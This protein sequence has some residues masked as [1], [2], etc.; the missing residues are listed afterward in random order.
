[1]TKG[2]V[3]LVGAG[4]GDP[5]LM[6]VRARDLLRRADVV[7]P[8]RLAP[9]DLE[10]LAPDAR[11]AQP[12]RLIR[13]ARAGRRVV[14]LRA[15]DPMTFGHVDEEIDAL[16]RAGI[17]F[18]IVPGVTAAL[19]AAAC[20]G[21]PMTRRDCASRLTFVI[22]R[23]PMGEG[24]V[25][26]DERGTVVSYTGAATLRE[27]AAKLRSGGWPAGTP[28][29]VVEAAATP[30][31]RVVE[32]TL[33][34]IARRARDVRAPAVTFVGKAVGLRAPWFERRP[35]FGR[36]IVVTRPR[37]QAGDLAQR[38]AELGAEVLT[39]PTIEIQPVPHARIDDADLLLFT[40][41]NGVECYFRRLRDLGRDSRRLAKTF[42]AAVGPATAAALERH[43]VLADFVASEFTS[44]RLAREIAPL[45][46]GKTVLHAGAD[47]TNP[48][49]R[50]ILEKHGA[51]F[52][53]VTLY[54]IVPAQRLRCPDADLVTFASAETARQF[55]ARAGT[56]MPAACIG[57]VS[58]KAARDAGFR[59]AA[60]AKEYTLEG[61]VEAIVKWAR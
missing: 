44:E 2:K 53:K 56:R 20:A 7:V 47:R 39:V 19:A 9:L 57:P 33:A 59:V 17:D 50:R 5:D 37:D 22:G 3:F 23:G 48:E 21:I 40:S 18:E 6:T 16:R 49:V 11:I 1:M 38:L 10:R 61:L 51:K 36:R 4:P 52:R 26:L 55:A 13:E 43:G 31:H 60:V 28:A 24:G 12:E 14:R 32:G 42:V 8:D 46:R 29:A 30:R 45:G 34:D 15:G 41:Q 27:L 54:R 35:L 58:A 25:D